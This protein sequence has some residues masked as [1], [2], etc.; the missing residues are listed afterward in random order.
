MSNT[1]NLSAWINERRD[2]G[3]WLTI[4]VADGDPVTVPDPLLW[5]APGEDDTNAD[6]AA[7]ILGADAYER[8]KANGGTWG[9]LNAIIEEHTGSTAGE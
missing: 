1:V 3:P 9:M 6:Y 2:R 4:E 7:A 8:F 5:P